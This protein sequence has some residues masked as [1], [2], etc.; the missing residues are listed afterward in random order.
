M[1]Y[2]ILYPGHKM[3]QISYIMVKKKSLKAI[4][5]AN[6][7]IV[8]LIFSK[9]SLNITLSQNEYTVPAE[10]PKYQYNLKIWFR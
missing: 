6:S 3:L 1:N 7:I 5:Y 10:K 2:F 9:K 4:L 8:C